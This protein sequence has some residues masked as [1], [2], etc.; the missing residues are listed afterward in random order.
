MTDPSEAA[1]AL[2]ARR[3]TVSKVCAECGQ[4]FIGLKK[5]RFC[6]DLCGDRYRKRAWWR[7]NRGQQARAEAAPLKSMA[8]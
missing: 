4:P 8:S 5:R 3:K 2:A 6:T 7:R 1:R